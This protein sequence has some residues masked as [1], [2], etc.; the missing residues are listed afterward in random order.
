MMVIPVP[1][2]LTLATRLPALPCL[3][4][5]NTTE[6]DRYFKKLPVSG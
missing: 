4:R 2:P 3:G 5:G 6:L 1:Q